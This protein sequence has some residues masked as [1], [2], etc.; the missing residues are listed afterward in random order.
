MN[1]E[2]ECVMYEFDHVR[3]LQHEG[4]EDSF[5]VKVDL[6][7]CCSVNASKQDLERRNTD[8]TDGMKLKSR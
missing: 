6:C 1:P 8:R 3:L 2:T 4:H 7:A 5:I